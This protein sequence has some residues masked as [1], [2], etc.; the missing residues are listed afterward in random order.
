MKNNHFTQF[1]PLSRI[2]PFN[3]ALNKYLQS[4]SEDAAIDAELKRLNE[5]RIR[6]ACH[7][8]NRAA[9]IA[10][11]MKRKNGMEQF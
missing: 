6:L 9:A 10:A 5:N 4:Q 2:S 11:K 8:K 3:D 1:A 7:Q